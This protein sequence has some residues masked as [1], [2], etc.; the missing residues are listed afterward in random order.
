MIWFVS[1]W[2][3]FVVTFS[4][5]FSQSSSWLI[6]RRAQ[7]LILK[8]ESDCFFL[9]FYNFKQCATKFSFFFANTTKIRMRKRDQHLFAR[10]GSGRILCKNHNPSS[11]FLHDVSTYF[12][13]FWK[14]QLLHLGNQ[15]MLQ[16]F[17]E[18]NMRFS[19]EFQISEKI[20][21]KN[22]EV[23]IKHRVRDTNAMHC[24]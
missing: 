12:E 9:I 19:K 15:E 21:L 2:Y 1:I 20:K 10:P 16:K 5:S 7:S 17:Y 11:L 4:F 3:I 22:L 6:L 14:F 13:Y 24:T 23:Y 18:T 8:L